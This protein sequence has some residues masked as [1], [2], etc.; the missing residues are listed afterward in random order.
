MPAKKKK[1]MSQK[2]RAMR[3]Q[4]KKDLQAQG[5]IPPDKP[6]LNRKKF[7]KEVWEEFEALDMYTAD[8]YLR[9]PGLHGRAGDATG[10]GGGSGRAEADEAGG[11]VEKI[12]RQAQGGRPGAVYPGGVCGGSGKA[13]F[14]VVKI[15]V[16]I[17]CSNNL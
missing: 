8:Y 16:A 2:E 14:K 11:G 3:A 10:N 7:A 15:I 5:L 6:R 4:V 1:P 12:F 9:R 13:C 17:K